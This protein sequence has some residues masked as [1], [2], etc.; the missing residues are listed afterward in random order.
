MGRF[1]VLLAVPYQ[2]GATRTLWI[3]LPSRVR[4]TASDKME[5]QAHVALLDR[6][7]R[8]SYR[9]AGN[10]ARCASRL[11]LAESEPLPCRYLAVSRC[12]HREPEKPSS[13]WPSH[14][15]SCRPAELGQLKPASASETYERTT[16]FGPCRFLRRPARRLGL[17]A[18][19]ASAS[20]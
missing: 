7:A 12:Q 6:R 20:M 4:A 19:P 5:R 9:S 15:L 13:I 10:A 16:P 14:R 17:R 8:W 3:D 11:E 18:N 2:Y 1:N